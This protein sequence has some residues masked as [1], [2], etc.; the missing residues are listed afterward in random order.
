MWIIQLKIN[1]I[2]DQHQYENM[3]IK[4]YISLSVR[5]KPPPEQ[6]FIEIFQKFK[7]SFN[8]LAKEYSLN[9][10]VEKLFLN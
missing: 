2:F 3:Q 8:L 7:L 9:K 5:A 1:E 6:E 10:L 4:M